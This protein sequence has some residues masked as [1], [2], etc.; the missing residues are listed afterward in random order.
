MV[1]LPDQMRRIKRIERTHDVGRVLVTPGIGSV[2]RSGTR[3]TSP[4]AELRIVRDIR[5]PGG[6]SFVASLE[7]KSRRQ[8]H[9]GTSII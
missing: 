1:S 3:V 6:L 9:L 7:F 5:V 8:C 2:K 4:F